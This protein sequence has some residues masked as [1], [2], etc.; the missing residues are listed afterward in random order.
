MGNRL[1]R[2]M[3]KSSVSNCDFLL[4]CGFAE[5]QIYYCRI[6]GVRSVSAAEAQ[7]ENVFVR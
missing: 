6:S 4:F 5:E 2:K 3:Q 1:P 7:R